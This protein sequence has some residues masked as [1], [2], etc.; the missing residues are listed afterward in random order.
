[1]RPHILVID[2]DNDIRELLVVMLEG[3]YHVSAASN[4]AEGL[5]LLETTPINLVLLDIMMP[6]MNG[7][8]V[9]RHIKTHQTTQHIPVIVLTV[10]SPEE[11]RAISTSIQ[12]DGYLA[13][14]FVFQELLSGIAETLRMASTPQA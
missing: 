1:M 7:W 5:R 13:K 6:G 8:D 10:R 12:A 9:C 11:D 4:G 14:P 2:D 3:Q